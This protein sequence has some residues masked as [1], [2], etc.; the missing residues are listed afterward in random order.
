MAIEKAQKVR[1]RSE[2]NAIGAF[3]DVA[4]VHGHLCRDDK[5]RKE[6]G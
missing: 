6:N 1:I 3:K 4:G 2:W 5:C